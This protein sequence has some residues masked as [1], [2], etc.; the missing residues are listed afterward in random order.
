MYSVS[1]NGRSRDAY[2]NLYEVGNPMMYLPLMRYWNMSITLRRCE[3]DE[4]SLT[5]KMSVDE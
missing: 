2:L 1:A 3:L 5:S 4:Q